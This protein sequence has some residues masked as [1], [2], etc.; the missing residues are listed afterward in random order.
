MKL[1]GLEPGKNGTAIWDIGITG[2][3]KLHGKNLVG[4]FLLRDGPRDFECEPCMY[5]I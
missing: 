3:R 4:G 5:P 2:L 1:N